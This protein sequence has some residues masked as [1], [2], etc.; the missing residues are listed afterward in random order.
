MLPEPGERGGPEDRRCGRGENGADGATAGVGSSAGGIAGCAGGS[1]GGQ[2]RGTGKEKEERKRKRDRAESADD[3]LLPHEPLARVMRRA[4]KPSTNLERAAVRTVQLSLSEL[5]MVVVGEAAERC[6]LQDR[7]S[8]TADDIL[9]ALRELGF[10]VYTPSLQT[11]LDKYR[12]QVSSRSTSSPPP[13]QQQGG[14]V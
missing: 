2:A 8:L 10:E 11:L 4:L 1:E 12:S 6:V 7:H 14:G 9:W 3:A 13:A 5:V